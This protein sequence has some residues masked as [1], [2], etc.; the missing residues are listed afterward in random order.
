M[1]LNKQVCNLENAKRLKE[2]GVKQESV[3]YWSIPSPEKS[4]DEKERLILQN[5]CEVML[6]HKWTDWGEFFE[7]VSAFTSSELGNLIPLDIMN[8]IQHCG[9]DKVKHT[10]KF[11][12]LL[13]IYDTEAD[14]RASMLIYLLENGLMDNK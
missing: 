2:L 7:N 12:E 14:A 3:F 9:N 11:S 5:D 13:F 1:E 4:K 8:S 10:L 6:C